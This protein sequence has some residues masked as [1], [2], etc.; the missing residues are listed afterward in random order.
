MKV[1]LLLSHVIF[2]P[3]L[4]LLANAHR[5]G[6]GAGV[7]CAPG[8][9]RSFRA[10]HLRAAGAAGEAAAAVSEAPEAPHTTQLHLFLLS[11]PS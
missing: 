6:H 8:Q 5:R 2:C 3:A 4:V 1:L 9:R 10:A 7:R 11:A